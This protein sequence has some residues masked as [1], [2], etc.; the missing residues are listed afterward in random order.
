MTVS[1]PKSLELGGAVPLWRT[2]AAGDGVVGA[3]QLPQ[4]VQVYPKA[5]FNRGEF[6]V[7]YHSPN[8]P[9]ELLAS[10]TKSEGADVVREQQLVVGGLVR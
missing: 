8:S 9:L 2:E 4:G 3:G 1:L 6:V 7:E 10:Q 5:D